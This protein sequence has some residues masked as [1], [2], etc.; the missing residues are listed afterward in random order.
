[1]KTVVLAAAIVAATLGCDGTA[2][3]CSHVA[4]PVSIEGERPL[5]VRAEA[6]CVWVSQHEWSEPRRTWPMPARGGVE[7]LR[8]E[9]LPAGGYRVT[10]QQGGLWWSGELDATRAARGPLQAAPPS[11]P[12]PAEAGLATR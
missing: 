11:P 4:T 7:D 6:G 10:F 9:A 1:M 8:I 2:T 3:R 12:P 5:T